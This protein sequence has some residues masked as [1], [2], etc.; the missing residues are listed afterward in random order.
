MPKRPLA[1]YR[2]G[3]G[4]M[5]GNV[6]SKGGVATENLRGGCEVDFRVVMPLETWSCALLPCPPLPCH[7]RG[8][9]GFHTR[10]PAIHARVFHANAGGDGRNHFVVVRC[11]QPSGSRPR[12]ACRRA[13]H[14]NQ[15]TPDAGALTFREFR[16]DQIARQAPPFRAGKDS[17]RLW[18]IDAARAGKM[19][20]NIVPTTL[21][22]MQRFQAYK[23]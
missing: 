6:I 22:G 14:L 4:V 5:S 18:R 20:I 15:K 19:Y 7:R 16:D 2:F 23:L 1:R 11:A 10:N 12:L 17:A 21:L 13:G 9:I 8:V 3:S